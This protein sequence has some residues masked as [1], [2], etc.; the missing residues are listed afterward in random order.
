MALVDELVEKTAALRKYSPQYVG[1]GKQGVSYELW[2]ESFPFLPG[3]ECR[4]WIGQYLRVFRHVSVNSQRNHRHVH[5]VPGEFQ[6]IPSVVRQV[7]LQAVPA[8]I[9]YLLP[10]VSCSNNKQPHPSHRLQITKTAK[11][12][13]PNL[14]LG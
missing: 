13:I 11:S 6:V 5:L 3:N 2:V 8:H 9:Q 7:S 1:G 12:D 4:R 14:T 10:D